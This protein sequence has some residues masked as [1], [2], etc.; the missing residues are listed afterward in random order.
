[1]CER[2]TLRATL[3]CATVLAGLAAAVPPQ[4]ASPSDGISDA[5]VPPMPSAEQV[6]RGSR[7]AA[8]GINTPVTG[9][10]VTG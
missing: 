10:S 9:A 4:A 1:M 3:L 2:L 6:D 8:R 5:A 7:I